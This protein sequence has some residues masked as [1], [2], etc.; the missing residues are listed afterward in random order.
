LF[1]LAP[2]IQ[3]TR[4]DLNS[5]LRQAR[6]GEHRLRWSGWLRVSP[7]QVLVVSQIAIS[8]LLLV[9]AGLFVRTLQNL[10]RVDLG[11]KPDH[12]IGFT[13]APE[14]NGY[15]A[16]KTAR[17]GRELIEN[18]KALP[19]VTSVT[20]AQV[21]T[22]GGDSAGGNI[23]VEGAVPGAD[24]SPHADRNAVGPDYFATLGIP[25]LAGREITWR[26]DASGAK[27][28]VI[29]ST[30]ARKFF[31][32]RN[33]I[34]GRLGFGGGKDVKTDIEVVGVVADSKGASVDEKT[35]PFVYRPWQ[36]EP[37]LGQLT[38]YVRSQTEPGGLG[39]SIR[40]AVRR[41][42][43]QLPV[44]DLK[45]LTVQ[46]SESLLSRRL[47]MVLS[48]AFGV[49]AALLAALGI[50]GVLAFGV[51]QR[52]REIGVRIALG[53]TPA[54]VRSL[55]LSEV[56]RFLLFGGLAGL[57]AAYALGRA[58]ES[59][60]YGV[61]AAD[62]PIFAVGAAL[63]AAVSFAAAYPPARR[64]ARTDAMEALRSE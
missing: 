22:L 15:T 21:P 57:P 37:K 13:V 4:V 26:D 45:T 30:M 60:L 53:A 29:N 23:A 61:K 18:L 28:A 54:D 32:G 56:G 17:F 63:L 38:F 41:L 49:L 35:E 59:I 51:A 24:D 50:Y 9:A 47:V 7:S 5:A 34:G 20:A 8:V 58:I 64:A 52:R 27:V 43:P 14:L 55:V 48:T 33:P 31:A 62:L 36:Q 42:D 12:L 40:S 2:A 39:T 6:S 25:L 46:I 10:G 16:E 44:F 3:S 1:G 11:L 19:G